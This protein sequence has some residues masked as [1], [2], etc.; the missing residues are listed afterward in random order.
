MTIITLKELA[1][2]GDNTFQVELSFDHDTSYP[3][4]ITRPPAPSE[5][6]FE[7]IPNTV[8]QCG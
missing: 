1:P 6:D 2:T 3:L 5:S 4:T 7:A 8:M